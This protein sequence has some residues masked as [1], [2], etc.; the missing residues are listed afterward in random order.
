MKSRLTSVLALL[1]MAAASTTPSIAS[2]PPPG[3]LGTIAGEIT[4]TSQSSADLD[5][6]RSG[7]RIVVRTEDGTAVGTLHFGFESRDAAGVGHLP[8]TV[9]DLPVGVELRVSAEPLTASEP[10]PLPSGFFLT[11]RLTKSHGDPHVPYY[12]VRLQHGF[13]RADNCDFTYAT[14]EVPPALQATPSPSP[15]ASGHA[16]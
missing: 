7:A 15:A 11:F 10:S 8:Y 3:S 12:A 13:A 5:A 2:R 14:L 16:T 4:T 9:E 6:I 1:A